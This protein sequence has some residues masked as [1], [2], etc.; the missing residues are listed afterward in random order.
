MS[1]FTNDPHKRMLASRKLSED[2]MKRTQGISQRALKMN[3]D[4]MVA[5]NRKIFTNFME[6]QNRLREQE[7]NQERALAQQFG[8]YTCRQCG[9][10]HRA[11]ASYCQSCGTSLGSP[12]LGR[13]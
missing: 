9:A 12:P 4:A 13:T 6:Q 1:M 5:R 3:Q 8:T 10:S 2:N 7:K 11:G